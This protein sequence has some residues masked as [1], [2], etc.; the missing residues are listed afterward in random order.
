MR[1][2]LHRSL[3]QIIRKKVLTSITERREAYGRKCTC[4]VVCL[5][6]RIF[7]DCCSWLYNLEVSQQETRE[8]DDEE[9]NE[10]RVWSD[11]IMNSYPS[12]VDAHTQ[13]EL[14]LV[15]RRN[16][17]GNRDNNRDEKKKSLQMN[18]DQV[19]QKINDSRLERRVGVLYRILLACR[20]SY[21][22][23]LRRFHRAF[24]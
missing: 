20:R 15:R 4:V 5:S 19:D 21:C 10:A 12:V 9:P 13:R 17:K 14:L 22:K 23:W 6:L 3:F 24:Q 16:K 8:R 7:H 11:K 1:H 18:L 2:S